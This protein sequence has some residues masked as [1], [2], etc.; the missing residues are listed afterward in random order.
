MLRCIICRDNRYFILIL[1]VIFNI[2][3]V[4]GKSVLF[5]ILSGKHDT[6]VDSGFFFAETYMP[7]ST[8]DIMDSLLTA[9]MAFRIVWRLSDLFRLR[10]AGAPHLPGR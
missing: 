5:R 7:Y 9:I 4:L 6:E 2:I 1:R 8:P 3:Y 10:L